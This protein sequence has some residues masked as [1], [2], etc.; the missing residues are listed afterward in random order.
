MNKGEDTQIGTGRKYGL[1][2]G[3]LKCEAFTLF[4]QGYS[5]GEVRYLLRH[6]KLTHGISF[7][8]TIRR[9]FYTWG[10]RQATK[11]SSKRDG[12]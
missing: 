12:R 2:P 11:S 7:A 9:Y 3:T 8:S 4:D 1:T 6:Y 5:P 10:R